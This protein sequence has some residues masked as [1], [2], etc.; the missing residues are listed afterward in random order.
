MEARRGML[1]DA[2]HPAVFGK[3]RCGRI[4]ASERLR[5]SFRVALTAIL[6]ESHG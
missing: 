3:D 5:G 6:L 1:L 4:G 2:K